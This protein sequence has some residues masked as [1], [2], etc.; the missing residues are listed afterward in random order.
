MSRLMRIDIVFDLLVQKWKTL[1][2]RNSSILE[3]AFK[4]KF[5]LHITFPPAMA[6]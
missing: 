5:K 4:S 3:L 1:K 2:I 6:L